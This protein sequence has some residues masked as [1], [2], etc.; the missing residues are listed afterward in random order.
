MLQPLAQFIDRVGEPTSGVFG[1]TIGA[2]YWI[3]SWR[4][5]LLNCVRIEAV[6]YSFRSQSQGH[7]RV[8]F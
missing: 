1:S 7:V 6:E 5:K 2:L 8:A 3:H 4:L